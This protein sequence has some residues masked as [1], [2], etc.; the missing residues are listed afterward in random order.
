MSIHEELQSVYEAYATSYR[1]KHPVG[2]AAVF[3]DD[4]EV[5]SPYA[6]PAKGRAAIEALHSEW[7]N[8]SGDNKEL[9]VLD[10]GFSGDLAWCLTAYSDTMEA[11][12]SLNVFQRQADGGWLIRICSLN[13][14][15][16]T[17]E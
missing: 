14:S 1:N 2:C 9:S 15:H 4:G 11:G 7:V 3:T 6:P 8:I 12:T 5:F 17:T 13:Q 16:V 10:A